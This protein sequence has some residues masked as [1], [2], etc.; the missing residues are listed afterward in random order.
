MTNDLS[1]FKTLVIF[2]VNRSVRC[3]MS[4]GSSHV[5]TVS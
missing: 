2:S 1:R 5:T 4:V 3:L